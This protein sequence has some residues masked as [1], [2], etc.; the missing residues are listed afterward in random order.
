MPG[1]IEA[2]CHTTMSP[3]WRMRSILDLNRHLKL[4]D[5]QFSISIEKGVTAVRDCGAFPQ[6]LKVIMRRID[7]GT[8]KGPRIVYCNS[9]MNIRG[10][11]PEVLAEDV[12]RLAF[13][14]EPF[15]GKNKTDFRSADDLAHEL[16]T[17]TQGGASFLKLTVDNESIFLK[18][19]KLPTYTGKMLQMFVKTHEKLG[20]PMVCH[21]H[22]K[23]GFDRITKYPIHSLEHLLGD[24]VLSEKEALM[25]AEKHIAIVPTIIVAQSLMIEEAFD[26]VP[27]ELRSDFLD[28]ELEARRRYI[29]GSEATQ[30]CDPVLHQDN[31]DQLK[32][33]KTMGWDNLWRNKKFMVDPRLYFGVVKNAP[34][35]LKRMHEAGVLIGCGTDAG[36]PFTYF[37][38][39]Y[40]ELEAYARAGFRNAEILRFA[41][42]NNARILGLED[43][44]GSL[45]KGKYADFIVLDG[46]PLA[47]LKVLRQPL[48]VFKSGRLMHTVVGFQAHG[49][50]LRMT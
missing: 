8:L 11:H 27:A 41:T 31:I 19:E 20:L 37:G 49:Q 32:L 38:G 18:K 35:N 10:G 5:R 21:C 16:E 47:D 4:M 25:M 43:R 7:K 30:H 12:N 1:L 42:V 3:V 9:M 22:R 26:E 46:D 36:M 34:A 48:A 33:Y 24:A 45:E 40:R 14:V 28:A 17:N 44:I 15:L 29:Y 6:Q 23:W 13:L 50:A 2:H 39:Y